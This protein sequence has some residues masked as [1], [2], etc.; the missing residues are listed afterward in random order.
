MYARRVA[1]SKSDIASF[2]YALAALKAA[3]RPAPS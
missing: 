2:T 3:K 1:V